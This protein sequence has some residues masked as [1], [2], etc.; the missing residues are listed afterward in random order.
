MLTLEEVACLRGQRLLFERVSLRL[1]PGE[2]ALVT[3]PNGAGKS[4]LLRIA[5]G[6]L[7]PSA[8]RIER[9]ARIALEGELSALDPDQALGVALSFW[10][11]LDGVGADAVLRALDRL[12]LQA[13]APVPVRFLSTGQ[14]RRAGLARLAAGGARVWLL[15]EPGNGLDRAALERLDALLADHRADG[16]AVLAATHTPLGLPGAREVRL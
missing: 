2:A 7:R 13:L 12:D 14:R 10:A 4:S 11:R 16:G 6:L 3:G 15:D 1:G 5:A 8:G 9:G